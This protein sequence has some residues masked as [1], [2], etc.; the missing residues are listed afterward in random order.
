MGDL[1]MAAQAANLNEL[2]LVLNLRQAGDGGQIDQRRG[3]GESLLHG[4]DQGHSTG[5]DFGVLNALKHL[6]RLLNGL[7]F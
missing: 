3:R 6:N 4:R 1:V 5:N 2:T 7:G